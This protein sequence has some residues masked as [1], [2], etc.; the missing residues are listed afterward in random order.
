MQKTTKKLIVAVL[1]FS[2]VTM[3]G[4]MPMVQ[5]AGLDS[6]KD[7]ITDSDLDAID[8]T[9]TITFDMKNALALGE[10]VTVTFADEFTLDQVS[11]VTCP[12]DA[13]AGLALQVVT[14]TVVTPLVATALVIEVLNVDNPTTGNGAGSYSV[15]VSTDNAIEAESTETLVYI[16][17]D[18]TMSAHVDA[19]LT[20]GVTLLAA[21]TSINGTN[22]TV[23][24]TATTI[25]FGDLA[26]DTPAIVG[27]RLNVTTNAG[28][29]YTVT[30]QQ[31]AD[32][33]SAAG[34]DINAAATA[35]NTWTSP[36]N[37]LLDDTT[38]GKMGFTSN[39]TTITGGNFGA[40]EYRG[41]DGTTPVPVMFH[42]GPAD[43]S[44]ADVGQASV[45]YQIEIASLQEAGDYET[46][47]TYVC[48]PTF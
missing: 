6:V 48:T 47:L 2:M 31:T 44:T 40:N 25:P 46:T 39:D 33:V 42:D 30:V 8:V 23:E 38:Y 15:T 1:M 36:A 22:T 27:Q 37:T 20:F 41:F 19:T 4:T 28:S 9:H 43:G 26:L 7:V 21:A 24:S 16:I 14:C 13:T 3:Y 45:A 35:M 12:S 29:G 34:D 32:M 18:V 11:D 10:I 5:A 17:D